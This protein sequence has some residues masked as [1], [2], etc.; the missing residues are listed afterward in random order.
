M[1][2]ACA[3]LGDLAASCE[4]HLLVLLLL[5]LTCQ[6][7][8]RLGGPCP[9]PPC[10]VPFRGWSPGTRRVSA[11]LPKGGGRFGRIGR[12]CPLLLWLPLLDLGMGQCWSENTLP[13]T[14][15]RAPSASTEFGV[16]GPVVAAD[17]WI[18][19]ACSCPVLDTPPPPW[20][21]KPGKDPR[22][23]GDCC[24]SRQPGRPLSAGG[25][26]NLD[27]CLPETGKARSL[28]FLFVPRRG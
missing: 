1:R 28:C 25:T 7:P 13:G 3:S 9:G 24:L 14:L 5:L 16:G 17:V 8:C 20:M 2:F 26:F 19:V 11:Q 21:A 27:L 18:F 6:W 23:R 10:G 4:L 12:R 15:K 22:A